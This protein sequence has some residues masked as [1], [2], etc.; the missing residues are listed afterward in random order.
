MAVNSPR[1][2]LDDIHMIVT[3]D[4]CGSIAS[5]TVRNRSSAFYRHG[6]RQHGTLCFIHSIFALKERKNEYILDECSALPKT[7]IFV[8]RQLRMF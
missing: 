2:D 3:L 5:V 6:L 4:V 1:A 8:A 7:K